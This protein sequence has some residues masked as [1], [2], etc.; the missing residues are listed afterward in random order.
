MRRV[1]YKGSLYLCFMFRYLFLLLLFITL[2]LLWQFRRLCRISC[3][4]ILLSLLPPYDFFILRQ[5]KRYLSFYFLQSNIILIIFSICTGFWHCP[6]HLSDFEIFGYGPDPFP[7]CR[8]TVG[9]S[10]VPYSNPVPVSRWHRRHFKVKKMEVYSTV[11][12]AR[13]RL[14]PVVCLCTSQTSSALFIVVSAT[15]SW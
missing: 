4:V 7:P 1:N 2:K 13:L 10:G 9:T 6:W 3:F 15:A 14:L 8:C 11:L 12:S 5:L